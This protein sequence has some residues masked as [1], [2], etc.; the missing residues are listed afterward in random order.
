MPDLLVPLLKVPDPTPLVERL[1]GEGIVLR[2][3]QTFEQSRV[4]AFVEG[5]FST[6]WADEIAAAYANKPV[7]LFIAIHQGE[8]IGFGAYECTRRDFFGP[9]GVDPAY[10][11]RGVGRAL[12]LLCLRGMRE[13][14]YAYG[15]IGGAGPVGFYESACG[16][17]VI[18][19][20]EPGI[21]ADPLGTPRP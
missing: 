21:Y 12:L 2:R 3:A 15:I 14:G 8:V 7:T 20:S 9:T 10:R 5:H 17:S 1:R 18:P 6:G 11:G 16:A 13:M 19:D 4:R